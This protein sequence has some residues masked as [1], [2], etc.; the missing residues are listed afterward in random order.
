MPRKARAGG[1]CGGAVCGGTSHPTPTSPCS[2]CPIFLLLTLCCS[3][4]LP[5]Y[6]RLQLL[7]DYELEDMV[8]MEVLQALN[9]P[10]RED[11]S[12]MRIII[13]SGNDSIGDVDALKA[14][15]M[16]AYWVKPVTDALLNSLE[17]EIRADAAVV[18][19]EGEPAAQPAAAAAASGDATPS[20]APAP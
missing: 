8:A 20:E 5:F 14:L 16:H 15:G 3:P 4:S 19:E 12:K 1:V 6:V 11:L 17:D 9:V 2:E 13:V 10:E 18:A 7:L